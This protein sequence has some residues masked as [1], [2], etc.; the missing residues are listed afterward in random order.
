M[1]TRLEQKVDAKMGLE[2]AVAAL[3]A[4]QNDEARLAA[5]LV[6]SAALGRAR[7][8][9]PAG[10]GAEE[11]DRQAYN[12]TVR[13]LIVECCS[14]KMRVFWRR[15][16]A[17]GGNDSSGFDEEDTTVLACSALTALCRAGREASGDGGGVSN[18]GDD[19][20]DEESQ[21]DFVGSARALV[22][23]LFCERIVIVAEQGN[24]D[25]AECIAIAATVSPSILSS[26]AAAFLIQFSIVNC[27][28]P[29]GVVSVFLNFMAVGFI[30]GVGSRRESGLRYGTG[31]RDRPGICSSDPC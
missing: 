20:D 11:K 3:A 9:L 25:A 31:I 15:L 29:V 7:Q 27:E 14:D 1:L 30:L 6:V 18:E 4:S 21:N 8:Q 26:R 19:K 13:R 22:G 17:G 24:S 16:I 12:S 10:L 2:D 28:N 5:L 23:A